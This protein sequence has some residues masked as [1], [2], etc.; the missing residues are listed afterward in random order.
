[1]KAFIDTSSLFKR[2]IEESGAT[3]LEKIMVSV[4][5]IVVSPVTILEMHSVIERRIQE[6]SLK[7]YD[8]EWVKKEFSTDFQYFGVVSWSDELITECIRLIHSHRIRVLDGIQLSS[9]ILSEA[10]L[11]ITSDKKLFEAAKGECPKAVYI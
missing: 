6:K 8:A 10:P 11:F 5:E 2:Y 1:M 9:A 4:S 3:E 7:E